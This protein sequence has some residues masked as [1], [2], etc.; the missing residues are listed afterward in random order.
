MEVLEEGWGVDQII[1]L[2]FP[3]LL[4]LFRMNGLINVYIFVVVMIA[5]F[6]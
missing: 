5:C 3:L 6:N 2:L 1:S 4:S